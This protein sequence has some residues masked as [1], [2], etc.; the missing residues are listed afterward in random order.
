MAS[1]V[2]T[3]AQLILDLADEIKKTGAQ[4]PNYWNNLVKQSHSWAVNRIVAAFVARGFSFPQI[5]SSDQVADY[6]RAMTLFMAIKRGGLVENYG[7]QNLKT[8]DFTEGMKTT[9][10]TQG[11]QFIVPAGPYGIPNSGLIN[12]PDDIFVWPPLDGSPPLPA[13]S[14]DDTSGI[15][16]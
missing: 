5:A 4:L 12:A 14:L 3:D 9:V 8:L 10:L 6:E 7:D 2:L 11:G 1:L 15:Q 16:W 13:G